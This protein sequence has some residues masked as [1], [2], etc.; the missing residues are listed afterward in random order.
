MITEINGANISPSVAVVVRRLQND[1][2][3]VKEYV[4][5]LDDITRYAL[6]GPGIWNESDYII[7]KNVKLIQ[8]LRYDLLI[9]ADSIKKGGE[10]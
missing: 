4:D 8:Q 2:D 7:L 6:V 5:V 1:P 9:L 10:E 3:A